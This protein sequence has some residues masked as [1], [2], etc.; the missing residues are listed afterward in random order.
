MKKPIK[1]THLALYILL[2]A[3]FLFKSCKR[4]NVEQ[5]I[6]PSLVCPLEMQLKTMVW[7]NGKIIGAWY[8]DMDKVDSAFVRYRQV[9]ADSLIAAA[10]ACR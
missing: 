10:K 5:V 2:T 8:D 4:Y 1:I 6:E 7:V 9:Q 3:S